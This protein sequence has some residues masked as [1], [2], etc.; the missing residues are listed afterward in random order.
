[1]ELAQKKYPFYAL[2]S[3]EVLDVPRVK[4]LVTEVHPDLSN[5]VSLS[6]V[7]PGFIT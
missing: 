6:L 2:L 7:Y 3:P 5:W 4:K 1:M